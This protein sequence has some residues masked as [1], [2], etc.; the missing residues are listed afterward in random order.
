MKPQDVGLLKFGDTIQ[1][2]G[3]VWRGGS[4]NEP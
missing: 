4:G 3:G 1:L 2:I